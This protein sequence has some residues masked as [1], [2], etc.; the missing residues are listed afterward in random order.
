MD[1]RAILAPAVDA[2]IELVRVFDGTVNRELGD[3]IMALF[4]APFSQEDHAVR[5]CCAALRMHETAA[6]LHPAF[7][8]RVGIASGPVLLGT[9]GT[10]VP[11]TYLAFGPT[12]HVAARLQ[13]LAR[14]G[15]T[16]CAGSTREL[17]GP[18]VFLVTLGPQA[19]RGLGVEQNVFELTGVRQGDLRFNQSVARGLSPL[20][21]REHELGALAEFAR[22]VRTGTPVAVT[23]TA[24]AGSGKS[25]LAWEFARLLQTEG[26]E[27]I[28]VEALSVWT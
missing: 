27:L 6:A 18:T 3:G 20:V 23:I 7:R 9:L 8:L 5:A 1:T 10:V 16:L 14:P 17:A 21:G 4:G 24:E 22:T 12:L 15:A 28:R 26:W 11:G 2:M 25:R 13:A 19:L